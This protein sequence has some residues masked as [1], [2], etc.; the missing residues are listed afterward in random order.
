MIHVSI[1]PR[2]T[3]QAGDLEPGSGVVVPGVTCTRWRR[4]PIRERRSGASRARGP[5]RRSG[6]RARGQGGRARVSRGRVPRSE[7]RLWLPVI[8]CYRKPEPDHGP[9]R[10]WPPP[11]PRA[12][13]RR[14]G[15]RARDAPLYAR[16][17]SSFSP[18]RRSQHRA[19]LPAPSAT[20]AALA[21]GTAL[22]ALAEGTAAGRAR[23]AAGIELALTT[24]AAAQRA[25]KFDSPGEAAELRAVRRGIRRKLN[26]AQRETAPLLV[27][28]LRRAL[29]ALPAPLH[30]ARSGRCSCSDVRVR[31]VALLSSLST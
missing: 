13:L 5:T 19:A 25:A 12:P 14:A 23:K 8:G 3:D 7:V 6:A 30:G 21:E 9:V 15:L 1:H 26:T 16:Q 20:I 28:Q 18:W 11:R 29:A 22:A 4:R 17:W 27:F 31:F 2:A 24:I 10:S